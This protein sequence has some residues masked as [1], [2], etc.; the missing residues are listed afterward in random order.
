M[1]PMMLRPLAFVA[2][3][4]AIA[5]ISGCT[6]QSGGTG[7][8]GADGNATATPATSGQQAGTGVG[9]TGAGGAG[10]AGEAGAGAATVLSACETDGCHTQGEKV[11][12]KDLPEYAG[13]PDYEFIHSECIK[14]PDKNCLYW[15]V[16][17]CDVGYYCSNGSCV[18][19]S[20]TQAP[21]DA[22]SDLTTGPLVPG[23]QGNAPSVPDVNIPMLP[24][25]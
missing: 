21:G 18:A 15:H 10:G 5:L 3:L 1:I 16:N 9:S 6:A 23:M 20:S 7:G 12:Y 19:N 25:I 14:D 17:A 22:P 24:P 11:C 13:N 2:V 8:G 4:V